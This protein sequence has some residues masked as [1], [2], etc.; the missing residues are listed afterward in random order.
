VQ[1]RGVDVAIDIVAPAAGADVDTVLDDL[2]V[3]VEMTLSVDGGIGIAMTAW[4]YVSTVGGDLESGDSPLAAI[5]ISYR[6]SVSTREDD[7]T[8]NLHGV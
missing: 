1:Q 3:D 2:A 7:P 8:I 6:G 5:R 4:D